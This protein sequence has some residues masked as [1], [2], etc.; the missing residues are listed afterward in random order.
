VKLKLKP[1]D[2]V[3]VVGSRGTAKVVRSY[4]NAHRRTIKAVKNRE[5]TDAKEGR[6]AICM[7]VIHPSLLPSRR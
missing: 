1:G 3:R 5:R 7:G 4:P 6:S 2:T